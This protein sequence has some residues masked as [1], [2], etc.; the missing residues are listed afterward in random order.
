M[1]ETPSERHCLAG[2]LGAVNREMP[3]PV[4]IYTTTYCTFCRLAKELLRERGIPF[5]DLDVTDDDEARRWL[6]EATGRRTV[7]QIFIDGKPIGGYEELRALDE[8][9]LFAPRDAGGTP[10]A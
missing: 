5:E 3:K 2:A 7:P 4:R 1:S 10:S 9:G 8:A 6:V